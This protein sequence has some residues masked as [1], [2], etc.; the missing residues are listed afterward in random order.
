MTRAPSLGRS[1]ALIGADRFRPSRGGLKLT[2]EKVVPKNALI[3]CAKRRSASGE[4]HP[5]ENRFGMIAP[6]PMRFMQIEQENP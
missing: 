5:A 1:R 3:C 6:Q 2:T 4:R